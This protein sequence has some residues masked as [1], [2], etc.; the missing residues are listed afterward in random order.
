MRAEV[1]GTLP[2]DTQAFTEGLELDGT[3]LYEST[4]LEDKSSVRIADPATAAIKKKTDLPTPMFG[5]GIT[6]VGS[7][8]WQLTWKDGVAIQRDKQTLAEL[9]RVRYDGE[10]WGLCLDGKRLVMSDGTDELTFRDPDT[11]EQTGTVRVR[12]GDGPVTELNELECTPTGIYANVWKTDTVVRIDPRSGEVTATI[13]LGGLLPP[14]QRADTDVLNGIAAV[15][16]TDEFLVTGKFWPKM[17]RVRFIT[18][19]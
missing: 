11:F 5:E 6:L 14:A 4:G 10:G 9:K 17:F 3:T 13:D 18:A 1:L 16:G 15:P 19:S 12:S 8:L 2:H 7:K